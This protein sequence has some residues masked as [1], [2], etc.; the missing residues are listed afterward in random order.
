M[1]GRILQLD[2][3]HVQ[4]INVSKTVK[5]LQKLET[6]QNVNAKDCYKRL[7]YEILPIELLI[8]EGGINVIVEFLNVALLYLFSRVNR[9]W[10]KC[11]SKLNIYQNLLSGSQKQKIKKYNKFG[12]FLKHRYSWDEIGMDPKSW[13]LVMRRDE[14]LEKTMASFK[15][16]GND[17]IWNRF[18]SELQQLDCV[19][20]CLRG[21][22]WYENK[23]FIVIDIAGTVLRGIRPG[24]DEYHD[25]LGYRSCSSGSDSSCSSGSSGIGSNDG[26]DH[27]KTDKR[28]LLYIQYGLYFINDKPDRAWNIL[29]EQSGWYETKNDLYLIL[30]VKIKNYNTFVKYLKKIRR[31]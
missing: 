20:Y 17:T 3:D 11:I 13:A 5:L 23:A 9:Y 24:H 14:K 26:Y 19:D 6:L 12:I 25:A 1:I 15:C 28:D 7:K 2:N 4:Y 29:T 21:Y 16:L 18:I 30:E 31:G 8:D 27:K 22:F 10:N